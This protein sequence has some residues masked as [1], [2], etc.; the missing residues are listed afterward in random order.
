MNQPDFSLGGKTILI[1]GAARGLGAAIAEVCGAQGARLCLQD[2]N[3]EV[4]EA[5]ADRLRSQGVDVRSTSFD[6]TDFEASEKW[7]QSVGPIWGLVNNAGITNHGHVL[8]QTI[9]DYRS[10]YDLHV[11]APFVLARE[12]GRVMRSNPG[13][14]RGRIVS[15]SSIAATH[16]R[17]GIGNYASSKAAI[18]GLTRSLAADF[19][20]DG[21]CA[22][23]IAPGY[24]LTEMN[25]KILSD[26]GFVRRVEN[27][28]PAARWAEPAEIA[29]P[30]A[31]LMSDAASYIN[32]QLLAVDGGMN[33][34]L[35][36]N[37]G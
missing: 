28:T 14:Q 30:V 26:E 31:F 34:F 17:P 12:A 5:T 6:L 20:A 25:K 36:S 24:V 15:L 4:V 37:E 7:V 29:A 27:R 11:F 35:Q 23:T 16:P 18:A 33:A 9:E 19:G 22:N 3:A 32:G 10:I 13:P 1:T 21:I 2:L 8:D